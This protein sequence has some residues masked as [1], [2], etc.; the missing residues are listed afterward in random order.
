MTLT[1][2]HD[3][4]ITNV[5]LRAKYQVSCLVGRRT[6][7]RLTVATRLRNDSGQVVHTVVPVTMQYNL[8]LAKGVLYCHY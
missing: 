4:D 1:C 6:R 7:E 2:E 3:L 5:N 8:V